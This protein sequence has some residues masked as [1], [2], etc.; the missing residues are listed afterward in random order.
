MEEHDGDP[1]LAGQRH[2]F[3]LGALQCPARGQ[4]ATILGAVGI[5]QHHRLPVA[6]RREMR[7]VHRVSEQRAHHRRGSLQVVDGLEQRRHVQRHGIVLDAAG[8]PSQCK[9]RQRIG[10]SAAHA[11]DVGAE[12]VFAITCA[13]LAHGAEHREAARGG[14]VGCR[15]RQGTAEPAMQVREAF[16]ERTRGPVAVAEQLGDGSVMHGGILAQVQAREM[17]AETAHPQAHALQGVQAGMVAAMR[18]QAVGDQVEIRQQAAGTAVAALRA[19]GGRLE[20]RAHQVQQL[21]IDHVHLARLQPPC[22]VGQQCA[23]LVQPPRNAGI[24]AGALGGLG[25]DAHQLAE[26]GGVVADHLGALRF[27]RGEDGVGTDVRVAVHVAADPGAELQHHRQ[28]RAL[29]VDGIQRFGELPV[30]GRQHAVQHVAEVVADVF[31][32]V[33]HGWPGRRCLGGLPRRGQRLADAF[34]VDR[35][36]ARGTAAVDVG[37]QPGDDL[38]LLLQQRAAHGL[39]GVGG[40]HRLDAQPRQQRRHVLGAGAFVAQLGQYRMQ[41]PGLR[42]RGFALVVAA[43]ADAVHALGQIDGA[44]VRGERA[45][46]GLGILEGNARQL[47]GQ[48]V[49]RQRGLAPRD[50]GAAYRLDFFQQFGR[51]LLGEHVAHQRAEAAHIIAQQG[52]GVGEPDRFAQGV[53]FGSARRRGGRGG[54][55]ARRLHGRHA[56]TTCTSVDPAR[57]YQTPASSVSAV[58][59]HWRTVT[60]WRCSAAS[61]SVNCAASS[62]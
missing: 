16:V 45:H 15:V 13:G 30:I 46:H 17:E 57:S 26:I 34:H 41:P 11:D 22:G 32:L 28:L 8:H 42:R 29:P 35:T 1:G 20:A 56:S 51:P 39:G 50:R 52:V 60:S 10:G 19:L 61:A 27:Q 59:I 21:A 3:G 9:H 33:E 49:D 6:A 47:V 43:A 36:L 58:A 2:Q 53:V 18:A 37:H 48:F 25:E 4:H 62:S 12:R 31:H 40:E 55:H 5:P 14:V 38:A 54:V 23:V 24:D 7:A 44:E